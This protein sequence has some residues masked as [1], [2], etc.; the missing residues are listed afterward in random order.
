[1]NFKTTSYFLMNENY[2]QQIIKICILHYKSKIT[3][4]RNAPL[5]EWKNRTVS[6]E[7]L[8]ALIRTN[9]LQLEH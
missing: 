2:V 5:Y 1:M 8:K 3:K 7:Q 4:F 9:Q 6:I